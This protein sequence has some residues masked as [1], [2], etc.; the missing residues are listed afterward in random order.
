MFNL[1]TI[2]MIYYVMFLCKFK[3]YSVRNQLRSKIELAL[4]FSSDLCYKYTLV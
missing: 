2:S 4:D 3:Y 1:L